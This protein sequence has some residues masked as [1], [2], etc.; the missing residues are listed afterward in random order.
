VWWPGITQDIE[1]TVHQCE[2]CQKN[3]REESA[4]PLHPL[5]VTAGP[6]QRLHIDFAGPFQGRMWLILVDLFSKWPEVVPMH[7]TTATR[8]IEEL[9]LIFSRFG[10]P[11]QIISDNGPQFVS[12]EFREF[13]KSNGIH[14]V[15]VALYH[16][17]SNGQAERFVQTFKAAMKKMASKGGDVNQKLSNFLLTYRKTPQS[18]TMQP[19][20]PQQCYS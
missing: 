3:H 19:W 6:W 20:K 10:L 7:S 2:E 1:Q 11:D 5:E 16:P 8:T 13:V 18:T 14:H 9:R 17:K 15:R 12:E 4:T